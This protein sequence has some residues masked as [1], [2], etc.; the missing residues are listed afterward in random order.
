MADFG[1]FAKFARTRLCGHLW[2]RGLRQ[3]V[4][5]WLHFKGILIKR[6]PN[7][8]RSVFGAAKF[9]ALFNDFPLVTPLNIQKM[10]D[11][12]VFAKFARTR[13]CGHLW[14]RG[15]R[16]NV[17]RWLQF[18]RILIRGSPDLRRSVFGAAK[19]GAL[20]ND[21]PL[22]P[23]LKNFRKWPILVSLLNLP[24][25]GFAGTFGP[26]VCVKKFSDDCS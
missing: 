15:L 5:R 3:N 17:L 1:V 24:E 11:F 8:R 9:G 19:I 6:S 18:K 12:G 16:Q 14:T 26:A 23:A 20:F 10:A 25:L 2:T 21:F 4:L 13:L 7:L 22:V